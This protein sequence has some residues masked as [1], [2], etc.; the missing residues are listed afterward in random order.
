MPRPRPR[1]KSA[2]SVRRTAAALAGGALVVLPTL[3][4]GSLPAPVVVADSGN[5]LPDQAAPLQPPNI[6][7]PPIAVDGSL[8]QPPVPMPLVVPGGHAGS[9]GISGPLGI[10][11]SMLKAYKNAAE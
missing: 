2:R 9:A 6:V 7:M 4:T 8:P 10:P 11:A 3:T 5:A 1:R